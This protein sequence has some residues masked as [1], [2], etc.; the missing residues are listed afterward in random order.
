MAQKRKTKIAGKKKSA[1]LKQS[2]L[3]EAKNQNQKIS[4]ILKG[5]YLNQK[6]L[7]ENSNDSYAFT[8]MFCASPNCLS[9]PKNLTA[10]SAS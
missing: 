8:K 5:K 6:I 3:S 2:V 1:L 9:K 4:E 10:F 7:F